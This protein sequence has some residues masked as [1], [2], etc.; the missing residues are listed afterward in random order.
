MRANV[1]VQ[2]RAV[3]VSQSCSRLRDMPVP[4][5]VCQPRAPDSTGK[6]A[7]QGKDGGE[8]RKGGGEAQAAAGKTER[9]HGTTHDASANRDNGN[10]D[11]QGQVGR[12]H[13][14]GDTTGGW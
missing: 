7:I 8:H 5:A 14:D 4:G 10:G 12:E 6:Y 1:D 11:R 13:E 9:G 3:R 2:D